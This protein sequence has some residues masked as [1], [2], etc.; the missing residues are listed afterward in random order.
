MSEKEGPYAYAGSPHMIA[1]HAGEEID[2]FVALV[3][4]FSPGWLATFL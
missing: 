2:D 1:R 4:C 3:F